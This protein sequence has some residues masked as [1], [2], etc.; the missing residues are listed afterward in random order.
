MGLAM[1]LLSKPGRR[2]TEGAEPW[3]GVAFARDDY[4]GIP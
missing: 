2:I 3:D 1:T 4:M